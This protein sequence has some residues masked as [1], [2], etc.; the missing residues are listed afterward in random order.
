[1]MMIFLVPSRSSDL[2]PVE[3]WDVMEE[4]ILSND[5]QP[6][7][8]QQL[9][10]VANLCGECLWH[11]WMYDTKN[12]S[13]FERKKVYD[14]ELATCTSNKFYF[15]SEFVILQFIHWVLS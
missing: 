12:K 15:F 8:V 13:I 1:M 9:F 5:V 7:D 6:A 2:V 4:E 3:H 10:H 11:R 14:L